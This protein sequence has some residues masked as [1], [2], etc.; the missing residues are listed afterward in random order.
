MYT[1]SDFFLLTKG[2]RRPLFG[3]VMP[4]LKRVG[5][6]DVILLIL[7]KEVRRA[8]G[9]ETVYKWLEVENRASK[10]SSWEAVV[11]HKRTHTT[12]LNKNG[13]A[14]EEKDVTAMPH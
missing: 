9:V 7:V 5:K 6:R 3:G 13:M 12:L 1:F 2:I 11:S 10:H 8:T 14:Q 4:L